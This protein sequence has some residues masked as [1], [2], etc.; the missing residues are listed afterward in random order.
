MGLSLQHFDIGCRENRLLPLDRPH[1]RHARL[2]KILP[3]QFLEK[4][5]LKD[6]THLMS[7]GKTKRIL[8]LE[9]LIQE[10]LWCKDTALCRLIRKPLRRAPYF[11]GDEFGIA[12]HG[13]AS[14][15]RIAVDLKPKPISSSYRVD[16]G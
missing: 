10:R 9:A 6:D 13:V 12:C 4:C 3:L 8:K 7:R 15:V 2:V 11:D 16:G 5:Q 1:R 14:V